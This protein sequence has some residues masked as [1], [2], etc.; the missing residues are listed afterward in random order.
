MEELMLYREQVLVIDLLDKALS[1]DDDE[2]LDALYEPEKGVWIPGRLEPI[3]KEGLIYIYKNDESKAEPIGSLDVWMSQPR[4][5]DI[6]TQDDRRILTAQRSVKLHKYMSDKP[7]TPVMTVRLLAC[8]VRQYILKMTSQVPMGTWF[9][10]ANLRDDTGATSVDESLYSLVKPEAYHLIER[11]V[12][13]FIGGELLDQV[14]SF[15]GDDTMNIYR[16]YM[17][18]SVLHV[19]KGVDWRIFKYHQLES[20]REEEERE[21]GTHR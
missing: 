4:A 10:D 13:D 21:N 15:I 18:N 8:L 7:K 16:C 1:V 17:K 19:V 11:G 2:C 14:R 3:L 6:Y 20:D 5:H 9:I 12:F